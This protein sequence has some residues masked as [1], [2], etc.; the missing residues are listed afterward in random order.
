[1]QSADEY[2]AEMGVTPT[3]ILAA[4]LQRPHQKVLGA[5]LGSGYGGL[6]LNDCATVTGLSTVAIRKL[7]TALFRAKLVYV[8]SWT[9]PD[10][11]K[12]GHVAIYAAGYEQPRAPFPSLDEHREMVYYRDQ[13]KRGQS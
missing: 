1:M 8:C 2:A 5:L 10:E 9:V 13:C 6:T 7:L 11:G 12:T 4:R 3:R